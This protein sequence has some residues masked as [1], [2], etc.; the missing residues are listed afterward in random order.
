MSKIACQNCGAP[1]AVGAVCEFCGSTIVR[2]A[3]AVASGKKNRKKAPKKETQYSGW[4]YE[5]F[6]NRLTCDPYVPD[7]VFDTLTI[8]AVYEF[9]IPAFIWRESLTCKDRKTHLEIIRQWAVDRSFEDDIPDNY[10]KSERI[11]VCIIDFEYKDE[12]FWYIY[13][14]SDETV[15]PMYPTQLRYCKNYV[16][17]KEPIY[18]S[19]DDRIGLSDELSDFPPGWEAIMNEAKATVTRYRDVEKIY[20]SDLD[21][22]FITSGIVIFAGMML[23]TLYHVSELF[24]VLGVLA[25]IG[26]AMALWDTIS[27]YSEYREKFEKADILY[28]ARIDKINTREYRDFTLDYCSSTKYSKEKR[29]R[30]YWAY[31]KANPTP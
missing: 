11:E 3:T 1:G 6:W 27:R 23:C 14:N 4:N 7:D 26:G 9:W 17:N 19:L 18:F 8:T 20:P 2:V 21:S 31:R 10:P 16:F 29:E 25:F 30:G 22:R 12:K 24:P 15:E 13:F 5:Y 28:K